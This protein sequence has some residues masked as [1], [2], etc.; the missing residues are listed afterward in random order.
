MVNFVCVGCREN[1]RIPLSVVRDF[2]DMDAGDREVPLQ[3]VCEAC[4]SGMYPEYYKGIH[5]YEYRI[6]DRL[7]ART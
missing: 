3:F 2:D 7:G 6:E 4:G 1:E 5:G